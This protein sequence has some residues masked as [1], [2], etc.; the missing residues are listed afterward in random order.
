LSKAKK[1]SLLEPITIGKKPSINWK[2]VNQHLVEKGFALKSRL[3][4]YY[5]NHHRDQFNDV[6]CV[7]FL[8][9]DIIDMGIKYSHVSEDVSSWLRSVKPS[10][11]GYVS[12]NMYTNIKYTD[13]KGPHGGLGGFLSYVVNVGNKVSNNN[14][15]RVMAMKWDSMFN[16]IFSHPNITLHVGYVYTY[17]KIDARRVDNI[18]SLVQDPHIDYEWKYAKE[19]SK[20]VYVGIMPITVDGCFIEVWP[21]NSSG[22]LSHKA[23]LVYIPYGFLLVFPSITVHAGGFVTN[24]INGNMRLHFYIY[25]GDDIDTEMKKNTY[26]DESGTHFSEYLEH[27][28]VVCSDSGL[29]D[30]IL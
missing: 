25:L 22:I 3:P 6:L 17:K 1:S 8:T 7:P 23:K 24:Y 10:K 29:V 27:S 14:H 19:H 5:N 28:S 21:R 16:S 9:Q 26:T 4:Q 12:V 11:T 13:P 30:G 15:N 2:Y 18:R 20:T